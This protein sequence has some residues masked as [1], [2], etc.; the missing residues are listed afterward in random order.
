M[1]KN[2]YVLVCT[3]AIVAFSLTLA[4]DRQKAS[5]E[6]TAQQQRPSEAERENA[7]KAEAAKQDLERDIKNIQDAF[8]VVVYALDP[9]NELICDRYM[10]LI[11]I[12]N[13]FESK[14]EVWSKSGVDRTKALDQKDEAAAAFATEMDKLL[15]L[16]Q[17]QREKLEKEWSHTCDGMLRPTERDVLI[18]KLTA[19]LRRSSVPAPKISPAFRAV[20]LQYYRGEAKGIADEGVTALEAEAGYWGFTP[21][22]IGTIK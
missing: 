15:V 7:R 8:T 14:D 10:N 20:L 22:Q 21:E 9:W 6:P 5:Q 2:H 1:K 13:A 18:G 12:N 17:S 19:E 3:L 16:P 4:C 11:R